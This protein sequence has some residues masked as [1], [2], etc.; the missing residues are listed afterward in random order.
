MKLEIQ[1]LVG[2][3]NIYRR[4]LAEKSHSDISIPVWDVIFLKLG[5]FKTCFLKK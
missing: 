1:N 4:R 2:K 3:Q 5:D